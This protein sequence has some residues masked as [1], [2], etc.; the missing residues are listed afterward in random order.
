[1]AVEKPIGNEDVIMNAATPVDVEL[2]PEDNPNV[3][4][5]DDGSAVIGED[6]AQ[7]QIEFGSNLAEFM[8]EDDLM[9][10]SSELLGKFEDDK[11]SRK[12]WEET[13]TK[14]LDLLGFKYDERS[15]PFQGASGV[16]HPVLAEAVTQFQAQAYRELLPAGGPVRTQIIGKEDLPKQQQAERVQEFMN[17]QIMHVMEEYDPELDQMLFHLPLAGSAFKKVYLDNNLGRP[18]SKFV[19][20]DDLVVPYTATDLQSSERVTHIIKRSLNEV[21]KMT[22]SG[23]Y[24]D[25]DLQVSTEEDRVLDKERDLS[26]VSKTGYEDDNYTLLEIH[27][28]LDLPGFENDS[29]I[30]LPYIVTIDE[31]SG[32]VLSVYRNYRQNDPLFRKDQYFVHFKFLPGLGFYGFGLVHMLGGLSRTATAALRQ[33]IDAVTLANL[34]AGFKARGLRIRDDDN[35]LQPGEFRDVDAPSGDLRAGLLPLPYKEP[36]QTLFSL[37][38]FVVQTATRFAT[39]AD[40]KIGE[41]LGANAPV[42]TTMAMMERGTKVMSAIHKRLHYAQKIEFQLLSQIFAEFL[43]SMY[44]YEVEGGP[45]QIK[46]QDFDGRVDILPVSDPNIFSVAQRV[47]MAQTQLQL[48]QSNPRSHNLYEAYRRMYTALGVTDVNAILPPP[49]QP[50]PTDPGLENAM[51]LKAKPLKAFPQQNHDAHINAHRAFMSSALVKSN[52]VVMSILSSHIFEHTALQAREVV[53]QKYAE[54]VQQLQAQI[55]QMGAPEQEQ[56]IQAQIQQLQTQIESEIAELINQTTTQMITEEQEALS[57]DTDDPLIRLKE[58]ELQLRAMEMQRKDEELD[59]KL[60]VE[61]ERIQSGKEIAQDRI[62]S[63]EDIAQLRA[64]VNLSKQKQ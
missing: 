34:P 33:L 62:D 63:Q 13:Y 20:A 56:E 30:K 29:G 48:A 16:T 9:N 22:V 39:V 21:K 14:G 15:Q 17:Y 54:Q 7:P 44:P 55:Q 27:T 1:M 37:L 4:M 10:V 32:K 23:F 31:G 26:G 59:K 24:R 5:M 47:V 18:V 64:N 3:Q 42:G 50:S 11:S 57:A 12:D 38:G 8:T 49:Q 58:Q 40:Q 45:P 51:S 61:R 53:T 2:L 41:N 6:P 19:P 60:N 25:I 46:Q 52:P 28:D 43:P 36:S 35:P